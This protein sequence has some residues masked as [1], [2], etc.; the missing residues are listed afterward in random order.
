MENQ[1]EKHFSRT[2]SVAN[3]KREAAAEDQG[4][5]RLKRWDSVRSVKSS[6][7]R[8]VS[9][10]SDI[11]TVRSRKKTT[12]SVRRPKQSTM[13]A[14]RGTQRGIASSS[15]ARGSAQPAPGPVRGTH[16]IFGEPLDTVMGAQE[17]CQDTKQYHVP[18]FVNKALEHLRIR[19][20]VEEGML[21]I[22]ASREETVMLKNQLNNNVPVDLYATS[23]HAIGDLLKSFVRDLPG[24]LLDQAFYDRWMAI[25]EL[26]SV[27]DRASQ[28]KTL[29]L[30]LDR[31]RRAFVSVLFGGLHVLHRYERYTRMTANGL[32]RVFAPNVLEAPGGDNLEQMK[33]ITRITTVLETMLSHYEAIFKELSEQYPMVQ[34]INETKAAALRPTRK[35]SAPQHRAVPPVPPAPVPA[36]AAAPATETRPMKKQKSELLLPAGTPASALVRCNTFAAGFHAP[37]DGSENVDGNSPH[38]A[39]AEGKR[40]GGPSAALNVLTDQVVNL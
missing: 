3:F 12:A 31:H 20:V 18:V 21:R 28:I 15:A 14:K 39:L 9:A 26:E 30:D 38:K 22:A 5:K 25:G 13:R 24:S 8:S 11:V 7:S 32:A 40:V 37:V 35:P 17:D 2:L 29:L 4:E 33:A 16:Q 27:D 10:L 36:E 34:S 23:I 1:D 19:G 6:M